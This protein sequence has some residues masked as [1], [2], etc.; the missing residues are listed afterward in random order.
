[1]SFLKNSKIWS[2]LVLIASL[3]CFFTI[4]Y[5]LL[6]VR[7]GWEGA[8]FREAS[9]TIESTIQICAA[10]FV[11]ALVVLFLGR[12]SKISL[13][14]SSI[15]GILAALP[16]VVALSAQPEETTPAPNA[17]ANAAMGTAAQGAPPARTPPLNDISTDTLN[18]PQFNAV[19]STRPE[20][21]NTLEYPAN[22]SQ[23][24]KQMFPDIAPISTELS[25]NEAFSRAL[26]IAEN[27]GWEIVSAESSTGIIEAVSST[28]FFSF[29]DDVVIRITEKS[30]GSIV[31]IRSH[32]RV[33]R[34]DRGKNAERV[35][36]FIDRF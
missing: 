9:T 34:G 3:A 31:D 35:R 25:K 4:I 20:G 16:V 27:R 36:D 30:S 18:P 28:F 32:S 1:M 2:S 8:S 13:A 12:K 10:V 15:A 19:A 26:S 17:Q 29:E 11:F 14:L 21:S 23:L 22:G 24:Q 5:S 33:G 6:G 7:Q